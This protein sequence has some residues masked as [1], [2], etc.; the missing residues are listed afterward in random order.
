MMCMLCGKRFDEVGVCFASACPL[1]N[2]EYY[3]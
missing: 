1:W 2:V 3:G